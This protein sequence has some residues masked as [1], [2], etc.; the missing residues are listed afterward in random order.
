LLQ[1]SSKGVIRVTGV[2]ED[3]GEWPFDA[4]RRLNKILRGH[5]VGHKAYKQV[6]NAEW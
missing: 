1:K 3:D 5:K 4:G 6:D 2:D